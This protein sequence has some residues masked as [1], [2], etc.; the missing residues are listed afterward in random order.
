MRRLILLGFS[1]LALAIATPTLAGLEFS[2][3]DDLRRQD[4][5]DRAAPT[6]PAAPVLDLSLRAP[7]AREV[8]RLNLAVDIPVTAAGAVA[9]LGRIFMADKWIRISCTTSCDPLSV[10]ALDR[11]VIGYNNKTADL[12]STI[13][14]G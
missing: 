5:A 2:P 8:Y 1:L 9:G 10:N 11:P 4:P 7:P 14:V 12:M 6:A 13:T 3:S